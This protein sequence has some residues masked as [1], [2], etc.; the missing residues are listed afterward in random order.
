MRTGG[1]RSQGGKQKGGGTP[2]VPSDSPEESQL[3]GCGCPERIRSIA[4][5]YLA[6]VASVMLR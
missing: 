4:F 3:P 1:P 6:R 5:C 2:T